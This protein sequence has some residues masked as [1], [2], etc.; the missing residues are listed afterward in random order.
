MGYP[1]KQSPFQSCV[2]VPWWFWRI[3]RQM[4]M[5]LRPRFSGCCPSRSRGRTTRRGKGI[6]LSLCRCDRSSQ[7]RD[8]YLKKQERNRIGD[9]TIGKQDSTYFRLFEILEKILG[10]KKIKTQAPKKGSAPFFQNCPFKS[11]TAPLYLLE[12]D[13]FWGPIFWRRCRCL[14]TRVVLPS[15]RMWRLWL[16]MLSWG[17]SKGSSDGSPKSSQSSRRKLRRPGE[18]P[19]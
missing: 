16:G 3:F 12:T 7:Q 4:R 5:A 6:D 11:S 18:D 14:P 13:L 15:L 1:F 17:W 8:G 19:C 2:C 9:S 10:R